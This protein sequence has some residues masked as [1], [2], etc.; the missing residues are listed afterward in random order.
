MT[1]QTSN[2]NNLEK[3]ERNAWPVKSDEGEE[4][5]VILILSDLFYDQVTTRLVEQCRDGAHEET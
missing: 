4:G 2:V 1:Y 5:R 3:R